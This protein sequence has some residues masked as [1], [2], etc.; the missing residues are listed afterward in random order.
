MIAAS[1]AMMVSCVKENEQVKVETSQEANMVSISINAGSAATKTY[2]DGTDVKWASSGEYLKVFQDKDGTISAATS[3]EGTT[4]DAGASMNFTVAFPEAT[5]TA[6][7]YYAFYPAGAYNANTG[8][9]SVKINTPAA[10]TPTATSFDPAADLLIAKKIENGNT[11]ATSL[12]MQFARAIAVGKMTITNLGS[13]EAVKKVT[14]SAKNGA[15]NVKLAGRTEF[16]LET[17][18]PVSAYANNV[19]ETSIILDYSGL[20]V[21][22]NESMAAFFTCYPFSLE[23][24]DSFTVEVQTATKT[25]TRTVTLSG[26]Q[27]LSFVAGKA[28]RF[29]VNMATAAVENNAVDL[30][31][32]CLT[33]AEFDAAGGSGSYGNVSVT[34]T[35]GDK[36]VA[37]ACYTSSSIGIRKNDS[38]ND[39]Y[40]K[41]PEFVENI[42]T[43]V[44]TFNSASSST[45]NKITLETTADGKGGGIAEMVW[46]DMDGDKK[47]TFDLTGLGDTYKT[48]YIRSSGGQALL[49]KIEVYAGTDNRTAKASAPATVS[50]AVNGSDPTA[51]DVTWTAVDGAMGYEVTLTPT[52]GDA[53]VQTAASDATSLTI[54]GLT[55]STT[56]TPSVVTVADPYLYKANSDS[57]AGSAVSTGA[58]AITSIAGIKAEYTSES[59]AFTATLTDALVTVVSGSNF[60]LQDASGAILVYTSSHGLKAGDKLNGSIS[61]SVTKYQGNYEITGFSY[62]ATK[63]TDT[64]TPATVA[65]A[66]LDSNFADYE[67]E[68]VKIPNLTISAIDGKN[69]SVSENGNIIIYNNPN[70]VL[71]VGSRINVVGIA[72]YYNEQKEVKIFSLAEEDK[73]AIVSQIDASDKSVG[74][75]ATVSIGATTNSTA[76]ITYESDD[77]SIATVDESGV[78]TGVAAGTTT[79][80]CSVAASGVYSAASKEIEVTVT[81]SSKVIDVLNKAFTGDPSSYTS[82]SGKT[83]TSGAVYAGNSSGDKSSIQLRSKNSNSGIVTTATASGKKVTKVTVTWHSD[84]VAGR[85]LEI[86]GKASAYTQA[87]DLYN[88]SSKGTLLGTIVKGTST[89]LTITGDYSY[90]GLRSSADAMYL[91]EVD[92]TW[93]DIE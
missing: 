80:T 79:I 40:V 25:F 12:D 19:S 38:T 77:E 63:T 43:V 11:Q 16:N 37:Y 93:E 9:T 21:T 47:L 92:I 75:G 2:I 66:T 78:I 44:L 52:V 84:T 69:I 70:L 24:G 53:V 14:F 4:T 45:T 91:T 39:S 90:I 68:Y 46:G 76:T 48:A 30:R 65:I 82:W 57:K 26:S 7:S 59:V 8:V 54:S 42:K 35:H 86:Y 18:T 28:S 71:T 67:S 29:S 89:E 85:T 23:A 10:Q 83:G 61:G 17:V 3:A 36:W 55:A 6:F 88:D 13:T 31:Y 51:L 81:S 72:C 41:L 56:Y 60:Y 1:A 64:V 27:V 34:K 73:L 20:S 49:S 58:P 87:T 50:A 32:A 22:A 15:T 5:G 33:A 62:T 74:I